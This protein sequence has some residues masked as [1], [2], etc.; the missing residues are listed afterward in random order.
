[1][2]DIFEFIFEF[3]FE[4]GSEVSKDKK[5]SKLIRY[6]LIVLLAVLFLGVVGI[7][8]LVGLAAISTNILAAILFFALAI[9]LF[10]GGIYKFRK[11]YIE[12]KK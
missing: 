2:D 6:P 7:V 8:A 3:L 9:F 10:V 1:M 11:E 12:K 4:F 5:V